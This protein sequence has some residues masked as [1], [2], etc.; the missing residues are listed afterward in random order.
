[1]ARKPPLPAYLSPD[2]VIALQ[3]ALLSNADRLILGM[4]ESG[5]AIAL[6]ERR[7]MIQYAPEGEAFVDQHL[8]DLWAQHTLKL[9]TV[10]SFLVQE[11][12]WF[13]VEAADPYENEQILGTIDAWKRDHN[14]L[15]Q[16]GFYIDVN[17]EGDPVTPEE[18]ADAEAVRAVIGHV[19]Q[20]GWQL[21]LG[22]HI[23]GKRQRERAQDIPPSTEEEIEEMRHSFRSADP[24]IRD[25]IIES[26]RRG[27]TGEPLRNADY[28][29][30]A[31]SSPF[32][33]VGRP[34][35]EAQ[36][37]ELRALWEEDGGAQEDGDN[38][39]E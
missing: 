38:S 24:G 23:E 8:L 29:F 14:T 18:V 5:K 32:E 17:P 37:R 11:Q 7:V 9:E 3:D 19:H 22:E 20:I 12:Y 1:M 36:D 13:G 16:R 10:H 4:E 31:P 34:G 33:N 30:R 6:H 21:R 39:N 28:A 2:Q 27:E 35:Y 26:M 25:R 15:K